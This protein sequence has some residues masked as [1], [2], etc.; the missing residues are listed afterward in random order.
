MKKTAILMLLCLTLGRVGMAQTVVFGLGY[1][2]T[3][4]ECPQGI[5][6]DISF[7]CPLTAH[8]D[9]AARLSTAH[10]Q[11]SMYTY[12][13]YGP[14]GLT[15]ETIDVAVTQYFDCLQLGVGYSF[16]LGSRLTL[17]LSGTAGAGR[18]TYMDYY[19]THNTTVICADVTAECLWRL[20]DRL[21]LG[22]Y[23][24]YGYHWSGRSIYSTHPLYCAG[25]SAHFDLR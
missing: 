1:F 8:L 7:A 19:G 6:T 23:A 21:G 17:R 15:T 18:N 25:V 2:G 11:G 3:G 22:V 14:G 24:D 13:V 16:P 12:G 4:K 10:G 9:F 5:R 20:G